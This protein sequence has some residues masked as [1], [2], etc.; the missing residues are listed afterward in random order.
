MSDSS[1]GANKNAQPPDFANAPRWVGD[2][3]TT[4]VVTLCPHNQFKEAV[5]LMAHLLFRHLLVIEPDGRLTGILS[6]RDI[7][8]AAGCYDS[9][10]TLVADVMI[11]EVITVGPNTLLSDAVELVLDRRISCLP[12]VDDANQIRGIITTTDLL[13]A[14]KNLQSSIE[15]L[16]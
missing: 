13:C 1:N 5:D 3:M 10:S 11:S 2:L 4:H 6:D 15:K 16:S 9:E 7:L 8:L 12:V 14:L